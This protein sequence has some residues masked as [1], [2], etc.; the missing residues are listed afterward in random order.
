MCCGDPV[1]ETLHDERERQTDVSLVRE[2][3]NRALAW[4]L[5]VAGGVFVA[6][7]KWYMSLQSQPLPTLDELVAVRFSPSAPSTGAGAYCH[8]IQNISGGACGA[9][10]AEC[11]NGRAAMPE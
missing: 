8:L 9:S 4:V 6:S 11:Q 3:R 7:G 10:R 5:L 2:T 1:A